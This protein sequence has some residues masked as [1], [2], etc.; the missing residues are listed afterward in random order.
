MDDFGIATLLVALLAAGIGVALILLFM[1]REEVGL[2][3]RWCSLHGRL[4]KFILQYYPSPRF[5]RILAI[6]FAAFVIFERH[7]FLGGQSTL[8]QV[9][10]QYHRYRLVSSAASHS[11]CHRPDL[12]AVPRRVFRA[13]NH[14]SPEQVRTAAATRGSWVAAGYEVR[15]FDDEAMLTWF[16]SSF[17]L[18]EE[19]A[20][21]WH[22]LRHH[23]VQRTD[24]FRLALVWTEGGWWADADVELMVAPELW[25]L[26][27]ASR[28]HQECRGESDNASSSSSSSS[29]SSAAVR[30]RRSIAA[31]C[32]QRPPLSAAGDGSISLVLSVHNSH[33]LT[34]WAF[35]ARA[36]HPLMRRTLELIRAKTR[37]HISGAHGVSIF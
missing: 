4:H 20:H 33:E 14:Q 6:I 29:S 30:S 8:Y 7:M 28:M 22:V 36:K 15:D 17:P 9:R 24:V 10:A 35:A 32:R 37:G 21:L 34:Q 5:G 31:A 1:L 2:Q 16:Q 13:F 18:R 25:C 23:P 3:T 11:Q 27:P 12:S 19:F 26:R